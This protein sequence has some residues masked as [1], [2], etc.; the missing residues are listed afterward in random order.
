MTSILLIVGL[1]GSVT[2]K[3]LFELL[4]LDEPVLK[5]QPAKAR[6]TMI[7]GMNLFN[8]II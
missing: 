2:Y 3:S 6:V 7:R 4:G 8:L 5:E 1:E